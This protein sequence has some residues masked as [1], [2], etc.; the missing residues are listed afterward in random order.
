MSNSSAKENGNVER[1]NKNESREQDESQKCESFID[2]FSLY[3][4][5]I[6]IKSLWLISV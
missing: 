4:K 2:S 1:K 5:T 3:E 6:L